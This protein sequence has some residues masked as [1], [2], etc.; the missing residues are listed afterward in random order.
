MILR[1]R[2]SA[3]AIAYLS[4]SPFVIGEVEHKENECASR[5][6]LCAA[7]QEAQAG[8]EREE[9]QAQRWTATKKNPE[10]GPFSGLTARSVRGSSVPA[11]SGVSGDGGKSPEGPA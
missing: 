8:T 1:E 6:I 11:T 5:Y 2:L 4:T 9:V 7:P 10:S 3:K